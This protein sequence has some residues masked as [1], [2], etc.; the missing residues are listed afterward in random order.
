MKWRTRPGIRAK[1][2]PP[3]IAR[4]SRLLT[5]VRHT[6]HPEDTGE[7]VETGRDV[8]FIKPGDLV[9]VPFNVACGRCR[10]CRERHTDICRNANPE[11]PCG[12]Y[13]FNLGGSVAS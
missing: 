8:E 4:R 1:E 9:S 5:F 12:A 3:E 13:G 7:V 2:N 11:T 10:S 6:E